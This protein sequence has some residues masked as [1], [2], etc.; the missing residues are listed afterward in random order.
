MFALTRG[1]ARHLTALT[2]SMMMSALPALHPHVVHKQARRRGGGPKLAVLCL[3]FVRLYKL[4]DGGTQVGRRH[5][6]DVAVAVRFHTPRCVAGRATELNISVAGLVRG[7]TYRLLVVVSREGYAIDANETT[8]VLSHDAAEHGCN[9]TECFFPR[10]LPPLFS[11]PHTM[12]AT[13]LDAAVVRADEVLLA[14]T[15]ENLDLQRNLV[16]TRQPGSS[17]CYSQ[18]CP[19][20]ADAEGA[21]GARD[22]RHEGGHPENVSVFVSIPTVSPSSAAVAASCPGPSTSY[23]IVVGHAAS[24][25]HNIRGLVAGANYVFRKVRLALPEQSLTRV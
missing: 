9:G 14:T 7:V 11:G 3:M 13:I 19:A 18:F 17:G 24:V 8:I 15:V 1:A 2:P 20:A 5:P 6:D 22:C 21:D 10:I 4:A 23:C 16:L 12:R 25:Q